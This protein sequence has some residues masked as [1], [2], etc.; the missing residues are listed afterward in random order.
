MSESGE[1]RLT[2]QVFNWPPALGGDLAGGY[3][4]YIVLLSDTLLQTI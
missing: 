4:V 1:Q 3:L 2:V